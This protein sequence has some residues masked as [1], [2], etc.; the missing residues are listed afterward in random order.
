MSKL[1]NMLST[2]RDFL[3]V[4][5]LSAFV[6]FTAGMVNAQ[7]IL[8]SKSSKSKPNIILILTDQHRLSAIGAY[9]KTVCKTPN[10]DKIAANGVLFKNAY[11]ASPLCTP[12]RASLM[13]G[14]HIHAHRMGCN[15]GNY[16][17]NISQLPDSRDLLSR[18]LAQAGYSCG[19]TGKWHLGT[20]DGVIPSQRG[21]VGQDVPGHGDGGHRH[22]EYE[23]YI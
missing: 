21:F 20:G 18:R 12:A 9:G 14:Q 19:Y 3:K 8:E 1:N 11:T 10:L 7:Q 2:R 17:S 23:K 5:V 22:H 4:S 16:G 6:L 15:A 13:T